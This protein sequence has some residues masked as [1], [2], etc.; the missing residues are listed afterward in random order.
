MIFRS[1]EGRPKNFDQKFVTNLYFE[2]LYPPPS[3]RIYDSDSTTSEKNPGSKTAF[4]LDV[5]KHIR[6]TGSNVSETK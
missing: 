6:K 3:M 1:G 4:C 5:E 2:G